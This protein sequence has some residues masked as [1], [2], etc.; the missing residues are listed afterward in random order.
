MAEIETL[1]DLKDY[2]LNFGYENSVVLENPDYASATIGI[3]DEGNVIY[4][5][6]KMIEH[7]METDGMTYEDAMEFIDYNTIRALPYMGTL[8]PIIM[9]RIEY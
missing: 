9:Y 7:L 8:R 2:L 5:Y 1:D 4:D 3:T 6:E